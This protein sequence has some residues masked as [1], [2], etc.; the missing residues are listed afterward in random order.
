MSEPFNPSKATIVKARLL[1]YKDNPNVD[2]KAWVDI[3]PLITQFSLTQSIERNGIVG[4]ILCTDKIGLLENALPTDKQRLEPIE[5]AKANP[6][7]GE[8]RLEITIKAEDLGTTL[9]LRLFVFRIDG[10]T[11]TS[12][13]DGKTF[14]MH[15][16]S[17]VAFNAM[18]KKITEPFTNVSQGYMARKI[19]RNNYSNFDRLSRFEIDE[20]LPFG[21]SNKFV[22]LSDRQRYFYTMETEGTDR[23]IIPNLSPA[24]AM[25]FVARRSYSKQSNS[26]LFRFFETVN[27]FYFVTDEWLIEKAKIN[28]SEIIEL[29]YDPYTTLDPAKGGTEAQIKQIESLSNPTRVDVAEDLYSGGYTNKVTEID[30]NTKSVQTY[31]YSWDTNQAGKFV[32]MDGKKHDIEDDV[33]SKEFMKDAFNKENARD[34]ILVRDWAYDGDNGSTV[35][36]SNLNRQEMISK[37]IA[38]MHHLSR[39]QIDATLKGRLDIQPGMIININLTELKNRNT[40]NNKRSQHEQLSGKYLCISSEH[41]LSDDILDTN[42]RLTKLDWNTKVENITI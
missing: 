38:Y 29:V 40:V 42:L 39:T 6:L 15:F 37:R 14:R 1:P 41:H 22:L 20:N 31:D 5:Y 17:A 4:S 18:L 30:I 26:S 21:N 16:I 19:F 8:E 36:H 24:E 32:N 23:V 34:F 35:K 2:D 11:P 27:G 12:T 25:N 28:P 10:V 9:D 13:G 3:L 7:R 33:H